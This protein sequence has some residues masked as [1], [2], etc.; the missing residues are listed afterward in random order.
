MRSAPETRDVR[1]FVRASPNGGWAENRSPTDA[2]IPE[3]LRGGGS[4]LRGAGLTPRWVLAQVQKKTPP[5]LFAQISSTALCR[6]P[7]RESQESRS[8]SQTTFPGRKAVRNCWFATWHQI[9][10]TVFLAKVATIANHP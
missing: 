4:D 8:R 9:C 3:A 1:A 6:T 7:S 10:S 5:S 2:T